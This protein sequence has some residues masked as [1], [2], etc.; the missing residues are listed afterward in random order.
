MIIHPFIIIMSVDINRERV[1]LQS[2]IIQSLT[3]F[4][5][6]PPNLLV[7]AFYLFHTCTCKFNF[8]LAKS[9]GFGGGG[10]GVYFRKNQ[11]LISRILLSYARLNL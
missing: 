8:L 7:G 5:L 10:G 1:T 2:N 3:T 9:W 4:N 6:E 11:T